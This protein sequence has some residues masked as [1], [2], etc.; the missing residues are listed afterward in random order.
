MANPC[1]LLQVMLVRHQLPDHWLKNDQ[2]LCRFLRLIAVNMWLRSE[3]QQT[4][5]L[6]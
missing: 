4:I 3:E 2:D 6:F 1:P 5:T